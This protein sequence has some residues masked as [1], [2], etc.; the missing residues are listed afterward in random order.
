ME[1][2]FGE[3][4]PESFDWRDYSVIRI[5]YELVPAGFMDDKNVARAK[6]TIHNGIYQMEYG[7]VFTADS[8]GFFK[9]SLI[10]RCVTSDGE[11]IMLP[12]GPV[13]F[14][15]ITRGSGGSKYVY[16]ID[17][18]SEQD[19]FSL[20]VLELHSDHTRIV[21]GWST[22]RTQFKKRLKDARRLG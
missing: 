1:Q 21:Y 6:A 13:W 22:N 5:P 19:N 8:E 16:G 3:E 12:S 17:P 9:R 10:E 18:A 15:V 4:I 14:D 11:P 2:L 20:I 7:A